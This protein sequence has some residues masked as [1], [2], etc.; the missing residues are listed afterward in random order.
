MPYK[1]ANRIPPLE[2]D[3]KGIWDGNHILPVEGDSPMHRMEGDSP[4][5]RM[6]GDNPMAIRVNPH[7]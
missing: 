1:V 4:M 7:R 6:E 5:H 2:G 3:F